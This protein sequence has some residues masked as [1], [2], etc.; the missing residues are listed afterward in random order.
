MG[1]SIPVATVPVLLSTAAGAATIARA[2]VGGTWHPIVGVLIAILWVA[3]A[4]A[5]FYDAFLRR[6][7]AF[8]RN[9][10]ILEE[11]I[12]S[13]SPEAAAK[14]SSNL[15][16]LLAQGGDANGARAAFERAIDSGLAD[17][18]AMA[19]FNLGLLHHSSG[20]LQAAIPAYQ[21]AIG[22]G[23]PDFQPMSANNLGQIFQLLGRHEQARAAYRIAAGSADRK[24]ADFANRALTKLNSEG[25]GSSGGWVE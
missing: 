7:R 4:T 2:T 19:A 9:L 22:T 11:L 14:A 17:V 24:Q 18:T 10:T 6:R 23:H 21:R 1:T 13:G 5:L 16:V 20:D 25:H 3:A 12:A 15:G 8:R